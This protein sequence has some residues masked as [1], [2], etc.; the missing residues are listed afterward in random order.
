MRLAPTSTSR[1]ELEGEGDE[2]ELRRHVVHL[3]VHNC[4]NALAWLG[5]ALEARAGDELVGME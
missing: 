2:H 5:I 1:R 3:A 4:D